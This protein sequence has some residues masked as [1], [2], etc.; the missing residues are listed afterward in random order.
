MYEDLDLTFLYVKTLS[1]IILQ[2]F[3]YDIS[4]SEN[5]SYL[6]VCGEFAIPLKSRKK[7]TKAG[8]GRVYYHF[9][10]FRASIATILMSTDTLNTQDSI[11]LV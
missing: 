6:H 11:W 7:H 1:K 8:L 10:A 3:V 9:S 2:T 4:Q 5:T